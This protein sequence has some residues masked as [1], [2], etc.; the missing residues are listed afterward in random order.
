MLADPAGRLGREQRDRAAACRQ[1]AIHV[2]RLPGILLLVLGDH[3]GELARIAERGHID[4]ART[5][6]A[7]VGED[8]LEGAA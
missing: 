2:Q 1:S 4:L 7:E 3:R 8:Q 5:R 6:A